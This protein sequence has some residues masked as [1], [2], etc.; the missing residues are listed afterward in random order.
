M[1]PGTLL[2]VHYHKHPFPEYGIIPKNILILIKITQD[3]CLILFSCKTK[4]LI[5][6]EYSYNN[7]FLYCSVVKEI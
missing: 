5:R 3:H 2:K 1:K 4:S 6:W 7:I